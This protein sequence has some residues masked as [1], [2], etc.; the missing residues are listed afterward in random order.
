MTATVMSSIGPK[1]QQVEAE[2]VKH[3]PTANMDADDHYLR[4][5]AL[6]WRSRSAPMVSSRWNGDQRVAEG[7]TASTAAG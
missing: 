3:K 2:R 1:L 7:E 6:V 4:G 5:L